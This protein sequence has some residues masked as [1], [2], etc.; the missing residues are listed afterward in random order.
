MIRV[1][2]VARGHHPHSGGLQQ[3]V[4]VL[5]AAGELAGDVLS[6]W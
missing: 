2:T 3:I 4:E 1:E 6:Q 5:T